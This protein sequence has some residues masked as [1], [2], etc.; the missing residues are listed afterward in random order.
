MPWREMKKLGVDKVVSVVFASENKCKPDKSI[1]DV[2][3]KSF[4]IICS[5]LNEYEIDGTDYLLKINLPKLK[6][7]EKVDTNMLI[8]EG[9]N[10]AKQYLNTKL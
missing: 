8:E 3:S 9:Y 10:Q 1:L 2:V 4:T 5:E 6:L 7:L